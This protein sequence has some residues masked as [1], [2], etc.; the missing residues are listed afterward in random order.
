MD[1]GRIGEDGKPFQ[2]LV[3]TGPID[4]FELRKLSGGA[5]AIAVKSGD[6]ANIRQ[7]VYSQQKYSFQLGGATR[8]SAIAIM[9]GS[10]LL[11]SLRHT[12][13]RKVGQ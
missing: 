12:M 6:G 2:G 11:C 1:P 8:L 4:D 13:P 9:S 5:V 7:N 10:L 3:D